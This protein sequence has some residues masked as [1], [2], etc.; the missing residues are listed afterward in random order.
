MTNN[1]IDVVA[2]AKEAGISIAGEGWIIA[3]DENGVKDLETFAQ[4]VIAEYVKGLVPVAWSAFAENGNIRIW[5][6]A[7]D[8]VLKLAKQVGIDLAPLYALPI[9]DKSI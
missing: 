8:D 7:P 6:S 1:N 9:K 4:L 2:L 5:T 3:D